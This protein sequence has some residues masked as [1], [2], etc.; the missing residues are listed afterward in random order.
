MQ[1]NAAKRGQVDT[2]IKNILGNITI[3][4]NKGRKLHDWDNDKTQYHYSYTQPRACTQSV[5]VGAILWDK[6]KS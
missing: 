3:Q 4:T 5:E 6:M 2:I 1:I